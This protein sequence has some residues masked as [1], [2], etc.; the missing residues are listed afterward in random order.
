MFKWPGDRKIRIPPT[1]RRTKYASKLAQAAKMNTSLKL[2]AY[3]SL[4]IR[5]R[6]GGKLATRRADCR[7][8]VMI[9]EKNVSPLEAMVWEIGC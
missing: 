2:S 6:S 7:I 3:E 1:G 5:C 9:W 8:F 4:A